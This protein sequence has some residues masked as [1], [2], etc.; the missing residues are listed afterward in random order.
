VSGAIAEKPSTTGAE[1]MSQ[2]KS[3]VSNQLGPSEVTT[4]K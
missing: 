3:Y 1:A 2:L 4:L